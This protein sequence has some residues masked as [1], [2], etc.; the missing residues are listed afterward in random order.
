MLMTLTRA[1]PRKSPHNRCGEN[2]G[3]IQSRTHPRNQAGAGDRRRVPAHHPALLDLA[4]VGIDPAQMDFSRAELRFGLSDP[5]GLAANPRVNANGS[6]LRLQP[7]GGSSGGRGF[8]A[9]VNAS[10]LGTTPIAVNFTFDF[11]GNGALSLEPEAG[12][13]TWKVRSSWP[14]PSFAGEFLPGTRRVDANGFEASY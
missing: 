3:F 14:S 5:R 8:Y 11:R 4:S 10:S 2:R 1:E 6:P 9:W 13:T 7:G 12:D